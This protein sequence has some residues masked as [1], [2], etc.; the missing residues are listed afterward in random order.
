MR[1]LVATATTTAA[2]AT[3]CI[4]VPGPSAT[5]TCSSPS[6]VWSVAGPSFAVACTGGVDHSRRIWTLVFLLRRGVFVERRIHPAAPASAYP[7]R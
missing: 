2:D 5:T 3:S 6:V 7:D 1:P 4:A